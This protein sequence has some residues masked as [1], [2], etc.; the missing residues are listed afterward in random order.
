MRFIYGLATIGVGVGLSALDGLDNPGG[1]VDF[2]G[3]L[4]C[5]LGLGM[6]FT[7]ASD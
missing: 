3:G 6:L 2:I 1:P 5:L 4:F 7:R